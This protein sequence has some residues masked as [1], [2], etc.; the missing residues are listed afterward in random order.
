M[1]KQQPVVKPGIYAWCVWFLG[2]LFYF[3][4]FWLQVSPNVMHADLSQHYHITGVQFG[5]M[6]TFYFI[7]YAAM[8]IPAGVLFDRF[9]ARKLLTAAALVC[10]GGTFLLAFAPTYHWVEFA[11]FAT[12]IGSAFALLG[13][14]VLAASWF[15]PTR[16]AMLT[17]LVLTIGMLG[18]VGGQA[19]LAFMIQKMGWQHSLFILGI[20][21]IVLSII[22]WSVI[23]DNK[24]PM[25]QTRQKLSAKDLLQNV[26]R[27]ITSPQPWLV[28]LYGVLLYGPTATLGTTWGATF[29][30]TQYHLSPTVSAS[31]I[32]L[33]FIGWA[34]GS[35][36]F[37]TLS[38]F[39]G[40]R[41]PP[42]YIG[43]IGGL[44]TSIILI[45]V[46][47][48]SVVMVAIDIFLFGFFSS[49]FLPSFSIARELQPARA[50]GAALGFMNMINSLG[51]AVMPPIIG[52]ILDLAWDGI[53]TNGNRVYS[54]ND[55]H[56]A[57]SIIPISMILGLLVAFTVKET[58]CKP[59]V[60]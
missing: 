4:E 9:G 8:Q 1:D 47:L 38:D 6:A 16:F 57:F 48:P 44:L 49:A 53:M 31:L 19:P 11:R 35:P 43:A 20:A 30:A 39:I 10:T 21:G 51:G 60:E 41:K 26:T 17:G 58:F 27:I 45:Y 29:F 46:V 50:S 40:R 54:A 3:Y 22:M 28:A 13:T 5:Y 36:V 15:P 56:T 33:I 24:N 2:A 32:S 37:G 55:F 52:Y 23:R 34:V 18:A 42:M 59:A 12:G 14:L 7:A 25:L